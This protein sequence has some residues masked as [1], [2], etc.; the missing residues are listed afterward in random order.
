MT[1]LLRE[2]LAFDG[3]VVTDDLEMGAVARHHEIEDAAIRAILAGEDMLLICARPDLIKRA[4]IALVGAV[5]KGL[6][7]EERIDA[8]VNRVA[9]LRSLTQPSLPFDLSR[10]RQLSDEVANL[11]LKL[12]YTYGGGQ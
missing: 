11:N 9:K 7:S 12:K 2:E 5:Q 3:L 1:R 8:S 10:L 6:I 4:H